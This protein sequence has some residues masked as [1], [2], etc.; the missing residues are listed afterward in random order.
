[1]S[2]EERVKAVRRESWVG[3]KRDIGLDSTGYENCPITGNKLVKT[4][5]T[6]GCLSEIRHLDKP[7]L[8]FGRN[9]NRMDPN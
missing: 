6:G 8:F 1:M 4:G 7:E 2:G 9:G 5:R 3:L